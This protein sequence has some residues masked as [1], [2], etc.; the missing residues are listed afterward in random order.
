[1][2]NNELRY[3]EKILSFK[4]KAAIESGI[5]KSIYFIYCCCILLILSLA[6]IL[7]MFVYSFIDQIY[8]GTFFI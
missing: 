8:A 6:T 2:I 5:N 3:K 1:M 7:L 4:E